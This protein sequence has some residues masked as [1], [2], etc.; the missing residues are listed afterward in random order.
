MPYLSYIGWTWWYPVIVSFQNLPKTTSEKF[1]HDDR[2]NSPPRIS[3]LSG[4]TRNTVKEL[5]VSDTFKRVSEIN[6]LD[7]KSFN[8]TWE[9]SPV[10]MVSCRHLGLLASGRVVIS[11]P[12]AINTTNYELW[13]MKRRDTFLFHKDPVNDIRSQYELCLLSSML[14]GTYW[15]VFCSLI[16]WKLKN[17]DPTTWI[18]IYYMLQSWFKLML[19]FS[20]NRKF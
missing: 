3:H 8:T 5:L 9:Q 19:L 4:S 10:Y 11:S 17:D 1:W 14:T 13:L 16:W 15:R 20:Y 2:L 18:Y 7:F 12:S 6:T